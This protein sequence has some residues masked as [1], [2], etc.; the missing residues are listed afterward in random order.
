M[1]SIAQRCAN[2]RNVQTSTG[3]KSSRGRRCASINA[4]R[5][6]L[7][8]PWSPLERQLA[9]ETILKTL[10]DE[11]LNRKARLCIAETIF[12][13]ESDVAHQWE[14]LQER[15]SAAEERDAAAEV[16]EAMVPIDEEIEEV[17]LMGEGHG[18][19]DEDERAW[20]A[21]A[22]K[23]MRRQDRLKKVRDTREAIEAAAAAE[24]YFCR[25]ANQLMKA[26]K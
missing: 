21:E 4:T 6:G 20:L 2:R 8:A 18:E 19:P 10:E 7:S 1:N 12:E 26:L 3:P 15:G 5:L 9:L 14:I 11:P 24:R 25:S 16:L 22:Q 17:L 23:F 13:F